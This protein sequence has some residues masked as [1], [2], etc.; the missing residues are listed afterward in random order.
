MLF[1]QPKN[2]KLLQ[3]TENQNIR[4]RGGGNPEMNSFCRKMFSGKIVYAVLR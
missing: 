1:P 3:P 4:E 2:E